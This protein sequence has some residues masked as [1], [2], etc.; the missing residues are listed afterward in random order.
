MKAH[1]QRG[2][3]VSGLALIG[4]AVVAFS[5]HASSLTDYQALSD[6]QA[7]TSSQVSA[8]LLSD[9][10]VYSLYLPIVIRPPGMLYGTV[11][12]YGLPA[13]DV[14]I[15]LQRCL[16]W[17]TNP[18]GNLVC[19]TWDTY[20]AITDRNGW[21]AFID[22]PSLVISPGEYYTQT[23]Q[24]HWSNATSAPG[25]LVGWD[26][27]TIDSYTQ[28]DV[29]NLG[30][31]DIGGIALLA[32]APG[33]VVH[34]PVTFQWTP[35]HNAPSDSY[36]VCVAGGLFIPKLNPSD[37]VCFGSLGYTNQVVMAGP[38]DGIDYGYGYV[39]YAIVPDN[40][41]GVGYSS[42]VPFTFAPP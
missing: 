37:L 21:Y 8:A 25:R 5:V 31:F 10:V 14:N 27:R 23:Y 34:F 35:R 18:G 42:S 38:F 3:L 33:V 16:T 6:D 30:T 20:T 9:T 11:T 1:W 32:P 17:F 28:G 15:T 19:L 12:E 26:S 4:L 41:G 36:D 39:W 40:T 13:A 7:R 24:A 22:P 2:M 29:V